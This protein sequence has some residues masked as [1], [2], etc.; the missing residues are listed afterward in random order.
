MFIRSIYLTLPNANGWQVWVLHGTLMEAGEEQPASG[1]D[2]DVSPRPSWSAPLKKSPF[3][4]WWF[5]TTWVVPLLLS[6][7]FWGRFDSSS[8]LPSVRSKKATVVKLFTVGLSL[9]DCDP[10]TMASVH[11]GTNK[12]WMCACLCVC[13]HTYIV[14][15][16]KKNNWVVLNWRKSLQ[17]TV[18][19]QT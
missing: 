18:K 6:L 7:R 13:I 11:C 4:P 5:D 19:H 12:L 15:S 14:W 16:S 17:V 9:P 8:G 3:L 10:S 1:F 2:V